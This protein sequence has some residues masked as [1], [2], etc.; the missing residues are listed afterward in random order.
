MARF[1][2]NWEK[3]FKPS[4]ETT[5]STNAPVGGKNPNESRMVSQYL[6]PSMM[7]ECS[8]NLF[9]MYPSPLDVCPTI[10]SSFAL[11]ALNFTTA[12]LKHLLMLTLLFH[13]RFTKPPNLTAYTHA[14]KFL[15][16]FLPLSPSRTD[17]PVNK[18]LLSAQIAEVQVR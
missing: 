4:W 13:R 7:M 3:E 2:D 17:I 9:Y 5:I 18:F 10:S 12:F 1:D 14:F 16:S 15:S 6:I 11:P 8:L